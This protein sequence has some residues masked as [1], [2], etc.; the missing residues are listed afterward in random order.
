MK[1]RI[2]ILKIVILLLI[3]SVPN[4][5]ITAQQSKKN[6]SVEAVIYNGEDNEP[7]MNVA[8]QLY[9][10]PDTAY[11]SGTASNIEGKIRL[12]VAAGNYLMRLSYV[13]FTTQEKNISVEP[14]KKLDLGTLPMHSDIVALKQAVVTAEAPPITMAEDT[15]IYNT[16]AFR[17]PAGSMLEELIKKYPGVEIAEDGTITIN[18]K[19]V[20][21]ILMKGK[22]FFGTDKE[23]ALKNIPVDVVDKVKFYD[24]QSDFSRITGIDDGEEETVLDL[25]MK[26]GSDRGF[27]GNADVGYGTKN[28]YTAKGLANYFTDS[29]Q[30]TL[31]LS[32]NNVGDRGFSRGGGGGGLQSPK[33]AGFNFA[34]TSSKLE[35]GG[36]I[37]FRH[38]D[39]DTRSY[40]SNEYFMTGGN[41]GQFV[42]SNSISLGR[43]MSVNGRFRLEWKPDSMTNI[44]FTPSISYSKS[45]N[46][47]KSL[48]ATFDSNPFASDYDYATTEF[49][50]VPDEL[51]NIAINR[52]SNESISKSEN[53]SAS[54]NLQINRRL[55]NKG[56]NIALNGGFNYG[57]SRSENFSIN[58]VKFYKASAGEGYE[59]K[60]YSTTPGENWSYNAR[61]SYTEPLVKN[62]FLQ[63]SYRF[64]YSYQNSKRSTYIL[65]NVPEYTPILGSN[66]ILPALPDEYEVYYS[67]SLSRFS[68]YRNMQHEGQ[69]MFRYVTSKMN[70]SAGVTFLPQQSN[71][72]YK[73]NGLDTV[74]KR[75]VY[76]FTPNV[77]MRYKWNKTTTLNVTYRGSTSQPSMTDLLDVTDD[78]NPLEIRKG[79][80]GLKP[81]FTHR[82]DARF[83]TNNPDRQQGIMANIRYS[84]V[85]NSISQKVTYDEAT[86][87]RT[88][89]PE[90]INGNWNVDGGFSFNS[91]IQANKKFTYSTN[92]SARYDNQVSYIS[93][94][95]KS[96]SQKN[97]NGV[98]TLRE[99]LR[100]GYRCD[101]FDVTLNGSLNYSHSENALQP[102]NNMDTYQFSYGPS[103]NANI[104]WH[105]LQISTDISMSSRRGFSDPEF[106]TNELLWNAQVSMSMLSDNALT[107][108]LQFYDIL[109]QQ[110]NVSRTINALMRRD[111]QTNAINS[112]CMLHLIYKF[113]QIGADE[114]RSKMRGKMPSGYGGGFEGRGFPPPGRF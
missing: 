22:D 52:N 98:L 37:N 67:D 2:H 66:Y 31:V 36:N 73:Y 87:G 45:D 29:Q 70:L 60:R 113:N 79:N 7:L 5:T 42:N 46:Y 14:N 4:M 65:D 18:G 72:S 68:T 15:M 10:L 112:Y 91:A 82:F 9:S 85:L 48:S 54:A 20:N 26:K 47:S 30:Y 8:M 33:N 77:R 35:T 94:D 78:S 34:T 90:N 11:V 69:V 71:M 89:Q 38:N 107:I 102:N 100:F 41:Q 108:S 109:Q 83:N 1:S 21:R 61:L 59:R 39:T 40:S 17:V 86:G 50:E 81:S 104:P 103:G 13:G 23:V 96:N 32:A 24:K 53:R 63:L 55:N 25:Q 58:N 16:S 28:R 51:S 6:G 44:I 84:N 76:N 111:S 56:R 105:R 101:I 93:I 27:F 19:T 12:S 110:S 74:L 62:L 88:T 97:T 43:S 57:D 99:N 92:T 49:G 64:N 114:V 3:I 75:T 80:P 106:N 95:R